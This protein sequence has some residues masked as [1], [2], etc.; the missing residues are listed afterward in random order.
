M[1]K[2]E[3]EERGEIKVK[4]NEKKD[5][6][7][8]KGLNYSIL[9][10]QIEDDGEKYW[11]AEIPELPGCKSHGTTVEEA[12]LSV[13]EAK[14]DWILD[15]LEKGEAVPIPLE[16]DRFNGR[17]LV[18]TSRSLHRSL[19]LIADMEKLS[20]NQL[21]VTILAKEVGSLDVLNRVENKLDAIMDK[22]SRMQDPKMI[23]L[24]IPQTFFEVNSNEAI[25]VEPQAIIDDSN[26]FLAP[27]DARVYNWDYN[28]RFDQS[29]M[30]ILHHRNR[31]FVGQYNN[32]K[33]LHG[34][35]TEMPDLVLDK[36]GQS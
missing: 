16:R 22:L 35:N 5:I 25:S 9:L 8:Y 29:R 11:I 27:Y 20:L 30:A 13:D 31:G 34:Q 33:P 3:F 18:R 19:T 2:G 28:G 17:I 15:S 1:E 6:E 24:Q 26:L 36:G 32:P 10:H 14:E 23:G 4:I 12:V 7:Y 21:I